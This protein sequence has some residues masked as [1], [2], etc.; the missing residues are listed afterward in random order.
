MASAK[1]PGGAQDLWAS[2]A[3]NADGG[4]PHPLDARAEDIFGR[5][6]RYVSAGAVDLVVGNAIQASAQ[7]VNHQQ[8]TPSAAAIG[9]KTLTMTAGATAAAANDYMNGFAI[10][11]TTPGLGV[12]YPIDGH[13]AWTAGA[14]AGGVVLQLADGWNVQV[15][16]TTVSRVSLQANPHARVVQTPV[17]TLTGAVCGVAHCIIS[18]N[19]GG[20]V[21]VYGVFGTLIQGTPA[22][23]QAVSCPASAAGAVAINSGTLPI[24]GKMMATGI[25]GKVQAVKWNI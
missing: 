17:T 4:F 1:W 10:I 18:A 23:G 13:A 16:L 22:V 7:L 24:V 12:T 15:A 9:D 8:L 21:G 3:A 14:V 6:Y 19:Q 11:D 25:D 2:V 20:W 5:V